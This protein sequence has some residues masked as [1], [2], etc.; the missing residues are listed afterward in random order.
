VLQECPPGFQDLLSTQPPG[1]SGIGAQ[2]K[3]VYEGLCV[4]GLQW[5]SEKLILSEGT[6]SDFDSSSNST[7]QINTKSL[8]LVHAV[9]S[10][11]GP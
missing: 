7:L 9:L 5:A 2:D 1:A 8:W 6:K 11:E 4:P 3:G 10:L